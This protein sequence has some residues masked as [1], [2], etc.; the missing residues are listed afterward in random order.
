RELLESIR[1]L[2]SSTPRSSLELESNSLLHT[3]SLLLQARLFVGIESGPLQLADRAS[4]AGSPLGILALYGPGVK[5]VFYPRSLRS[6]ILHEVLP[7]NPCDQVHCVRPDDT[8]MMRISEAQVWAAVQELLS[9]S[10]N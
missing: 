8:C 3:Y 1:S 7:C 6:R 4:A 10:A 2:C 9:L 5:D